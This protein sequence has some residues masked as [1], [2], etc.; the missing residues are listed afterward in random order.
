MPF[1]IWQ[2]LR[3]FTFSLTLPKYVCIYYIIYK[4]VCVCMNLYKM[5]KINA[6]TQKYVL[7]W[8]MQL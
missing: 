1:N 4:N 6:R 5:Q 8:H 2:I 3:T 7:L